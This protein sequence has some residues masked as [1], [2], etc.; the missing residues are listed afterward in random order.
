M[1]NN[2]SFK[3]L[4]LVILLTFYSQVYSQSFEIT[5]YNLQFEI[6]P[7]EHKLIAEAE[8]SIK[9]SNKNFAEKL[10]LFLSCDSI[11]SVKDYNG[12]D[13]TFS[14]EGSKVI[15][16]LKHTSGDR[17]VI[18]LKYEGIFLGWVSNRIDIKSSWLLFESYF[19][20]RTSTEFKNNNFSFNLKITVPDSLDVVCSGELEKMETA[21]SKR[22]FYYCS[23]K[24]EALI[25]ISTA[26]YKIKEYDNKGM[27]ITSY[28]FPEHQTQSDTLVKIFSKVL[29]YYQKKFGQYPFSDFK[30]VETERRGGYAPPGQFLLSSQLIDNLDDIGIFTI[31]H[32]VAHQWFPHSKM[33]FPDYFLNESFAQYAAFAYSDFIGITQKENNSLKKKIL[34]MDFGLDG[35]YNELERVKDHIVYEEKPLSDISLADGRL[36]QW[37]AYYKGFY[38][39]RSL[40]TEVGRDTFDLVIRKIIEDKNLNPISA[41][42]FVNSLEKMSGKKLKYQITD[43]LNTNKTLDYELSDFS[44]VKLPNGDYKTTIYIKNRGEITVPFE[45]LATSK[46]GEKF[47]GK[48]ND[49]VSNGASFEFITPEEVMK[50]EIDPDWYLLDADRTNNYYPRKNKISFLYSNYSVTGD[51]YFYYPSFT[52]G[53]RDKVRLGLWAT[54]I[55]PVLPEMLKRNIVPVEW[56]AGLFYGFGTKRI[57]YKL[58]LKT[59]ISVPSYRW[60]AGLNLSNFRG[61]ENYSAFINYNFEKDENH[62]KHNIVNVSINRDQIYD[63]AYYDSKDYEKGSNSTLLF[64]WDRLLNK[65]KEHFNIKIGQRVF[66]SNYPY[67]KITMELENLFPV[68]NRWFHFR[69][70]GGIVRGN[71][72]QQEAVYLSGSVRPTSFAYWFVDPDTKISTQ[73]NLHT[74]GDANLRGYLGQHLKGKNGVGVN[75]EIPVPGLSMINLFSDIGNVWDKKF[76]ILKYGFGL[77]FDLK[78]IRIDFPFYINKPMKNEKA[79]AFRWL[80]E[81]SF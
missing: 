77:G 18:K 62:F 42:E 30:I 24:N 5:H 21:K 34:F 79:F 57:G 37:A 26:V 71:S 27:K 48:V 74:K 19:F 33:F 54:N 73:E 44:S 8:V 46:S 59:I 9:S 53:Q 64:D 58:D 56:R 13:L 80:L 3:G 68:L 65:E 69:I 40:A 25:S 72:P 70:F 78:Y 66:G 6:M 38:F 47:T 39:L 1:K 51:Q 45:I 43:W 20:P 14:K 28:L 7:V 32:E 63:I 11:S 81:L 10:E 29:N 67:S 2:Y 52:F 41:D 50:T 35:T 23:K 61:S 15:I 55:Y 75:F 16:S 60:E 36:Y 76:G 49:F 17:T 12:N 31:V 4:L 22:S